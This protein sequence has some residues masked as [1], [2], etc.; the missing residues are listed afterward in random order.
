ML[1]QTIPDFDSIWD[2]S[3][4]QKTEGRFREILLQVPDDEPE[5][6]ELLTQIARAQGLQQRF[7]KAHQTLDQ[8]ERRVGESVSRA[9]VRYLLE[10][11]R[12]LNSSGLPDDARPYFEQALDSATKL[13]EDSYAVDAL[14]MLALAAP[15]A[16]SLDLNLRAI[17]LAES[18]GQENARGWL[19]S[20][21]NN[22]GWSYHDLGEYASALEMFT[23]AE[24][25]RRSNGSVTEI[26]IARWCVA[27]ALRSLNRVKEAL[28]IQ[29]ELK[30]EIESAG[31]SDGYVFEEIG[32]CLLALNRA[33]ES[34]AYFAKAYEVLSQD[35]WL[36]EKEPE[37]LARLKELGSTSG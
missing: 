20:L 34:R 17:A 32:E 3:N 2:Y 33:K 26:R 30:C 22:A 23:K 11:G 29:R 12:V 1:S 18:S 8:V 36:A 37:R 21:Y 9:K 6:L 14:H 31:E 15:P 19:A 25:A 35:I 27:R 13:T 16:S 28:T 7:A 24:S 4:P 10:R 5:F